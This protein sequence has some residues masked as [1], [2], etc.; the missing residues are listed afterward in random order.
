MINKK[1]NLDT[2][3]RKAN[4]TFYHAHVA[5]HL[6]TTTIHTFVLARP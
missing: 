1:N 6:A 5:F 2:V 3:K 4:M